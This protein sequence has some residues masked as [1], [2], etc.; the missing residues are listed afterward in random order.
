MNEGE[1]LTSSSNSATHC[2]WLPASWADW[3]GQAVQPKPLCYRNRAA[4]HAG[5]QHRLTWPRKQN[6]P[7]DCVPGCPHCLFTD[8]HQHGQQQSVGAKF[9][10]RQTRN[11]LATCGRGGSWKL[12]FCLFFI[13]M[14]TGLPTGWTWQ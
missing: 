13:G 3:P 12:H 14:G 8:L 5:G 6:K 1:L 4:S 11:S 2:G 9:F 7:Q 10:W